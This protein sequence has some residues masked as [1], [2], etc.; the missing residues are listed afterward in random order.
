M[1]YHTISHRR[2]KGLTLVE[3]LI[4]M[5]LGLLVIVIA[6]TALVLSRQG[7]SSVDNATQLRDRER[8]VI[9]LINRVVL[10]AGF[11]DLGSATVTTRVSA[12]LTGQVPEPDLYGWN[13]AVYKT[14]SDTLF[15]SSTTITNG[16]RPAGCGSVSDTSCVNG[17][18]ILVV[19]YQGVSSPTNVLA[20]DNS[21]INCAGRGVAASPTGDLNER[22]VSIFHITRDATSG[23]PSLSCTAANFTSSGVTWENRPLIEGVESFQVLYGTDGVAPGAAQTAANVHDTIAERWLR[24]DQLTVAGNVAATRDNWRRVRAIRVGLVLRGPIGSAQQSKVDN[25]FPL[26]PRFESSGDAGTRLTVTADRRLRQAVS[27]TVH[28]RNDLAR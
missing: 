7:Y 12:P 24:A 14:L 18:D 9:D 5:G 11:E 28:L 26:G 23:E 25:L 16:N 1:T 20:A 10:Q 27:F 22:A 2:Q 13:N 3:L 8:F 21:I 4:A 6:A 15:S 17:S 19:R